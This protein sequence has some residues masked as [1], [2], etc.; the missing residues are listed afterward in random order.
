MS[1]VTLEGIKQL[2]D[3]RLVAGRKHTQEIVNGAVDR[4]DA[5]MDRMEAKFER[6]FD[7][8]EYRM[9]RV[10]NKVDDLQESMER[11]FRA[12]HQDHVAL[13]KRVTRLE[14]KA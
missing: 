12:V 13:A 7:S 9:D 5:R 1:E 8:L 2:L 6:R 3:E 11:G 10:E 14:A 4:L